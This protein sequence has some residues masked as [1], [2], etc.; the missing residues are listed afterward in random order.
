MISEMMIGFKFKEL[1][2]W[3]YDIVWYAHL[4]GAKQL[5]ILRRLQ[6]KASISRK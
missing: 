1:Y 4:F 3:E 6:F 2:V 5:T